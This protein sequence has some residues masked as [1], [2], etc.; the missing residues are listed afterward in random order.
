MSPRIPNEL[1]DA[2]RN[3]QETWEEFQTVIDRDHSKEEWSEA[4]NKALAADTVSH[5][6]YMRWQAVGGTSDIESIVEAEALVNS[7]NAE[8]LTNELGLETHVIISGGEVLE[9]DAHLMAQYDER[10]GGDKWQVEC[11]EAEFGSREWFAGI[12]PIEF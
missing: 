6:W 10:N 1:A 4:L 12:Q 7:T 3:A 8:P 11:T 5:T 9:L 2:R